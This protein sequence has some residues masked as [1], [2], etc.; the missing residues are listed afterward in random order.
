MMA[1]IEYSEYQK[2]VISD[3]YANLDAI[4][5]GKLSDFVSE[6]YLAESQAKKDRLWQKARKAMEKLNIPQ[7]IIEHIMEK[8]DVEILAKNLQDWLNYSRKK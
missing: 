3:Y 8:R 7:V 5:L 2:A 4:M 1:K 6:L